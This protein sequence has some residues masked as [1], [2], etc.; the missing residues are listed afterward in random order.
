MRIAAL[1]PLAVSASPKRVD[2]TPPTEIFL[3][4][5]IPEFPKVDADSAPTL[6]FLTANIAQLEE[7]VEYLLGDGRGARAKLLDDLVPR[8]GNHGCV[9]V[10]SAKLGDSF[11]PLV[12]LRDRHEVHPAI[13]STGSIPTAIRSNSLYMKDFTVVNDFG[14]RAS[15]FDSGLKEKRFTLVPSQVFGRN[16]DVRNPVSWTETVEDARETAFSDEIELGVIDASPRSAFM[17]TVRHFSIEISE[18]GSYENF[19]LG[20]PSVS[21]K[22]SVVIISIFRTLQGRLTRFRPP[23][24]RRKKTYRGALRDLPLISRLS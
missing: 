13:L 1:L 14:T 4:D 8:P 22:I 23:L 16:Y 12:G 7:D 3:Q 17:A 6:Q 5:A 9:P 21:W 20:K 24:F 2:A 15:I 10:F 18:D 11:V 19:D